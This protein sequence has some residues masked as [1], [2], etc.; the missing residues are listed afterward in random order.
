M[1]CRPYVHGK[2]RENS[3]TFFCLE[4][5]AARAYLRVFDRRRAKEITREEAERLLLRY[6]DEY[7]CL[8]GPVS[9]IS[10]RTLVQ[11]SESAPLCRRTGEKATKWPSLVEAELSGDGT[12]IWVLTN[13]I[14]PPPEKDTR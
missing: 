8:F 10:R 9:H 6:R 5:K 3:V 2:L 7:S 1:D 4:E 12:P 14:V 11:G 13:A